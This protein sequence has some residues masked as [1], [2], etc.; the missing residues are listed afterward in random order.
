M[1]KIL[2]VLKKCAETPDSCSWNSCKPLKPGTS[3]S[4]IRV[5]VEDCKT[6]DCG[7][8]LLKLYGIFN[9]LERPLQMTG[10]TGWSKCT[11]DINLYSS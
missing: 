7:S 2:P 4:Q 5:Y 11:G 3:S 10:K 9:I 6:V 8:L 1:H